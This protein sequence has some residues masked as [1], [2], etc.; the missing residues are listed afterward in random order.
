MSEELTVL[1]D[2]H[3][4]PSQFDSALKAVQKCA[5]LSRKEPG[6]LRYDVFTS[7]DYPSTITLV[8]KWINEVALS[9]HKELKHYLDLQTTLERTNESITIEVTSKIKEE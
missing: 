4:T 2:I 8:E 3:C 1:V 5:G 9:A 7:S 6:C